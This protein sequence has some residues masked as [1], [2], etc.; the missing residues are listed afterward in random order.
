MMARPSLLKTDVFLD[1]R[2]RADDQL[3]FSRADFLDHCAPG[4]GGEPA[5]EESSF[6]S[7]VAQG[8]FDGGEVL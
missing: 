1:D 7:A 4:F 8:R 3:C 5:G 6:D 2:L